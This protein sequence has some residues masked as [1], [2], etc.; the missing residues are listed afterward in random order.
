MTLRAKKKIE[1]CPK[2]VTGKHYWMKLKWYT[3]SDNLPKCSRCQLCGIIDDRQSAD[4]P[5]RGE[6]M[7]ID[8]KTNTTICPKCHRRVPVKDMRIGMIGWHSRRTGSGAAPMTDDFCKR[9]KM[10]IKKQITEVVE[11]VQSE[12]LAQRKKV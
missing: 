7:I 9:H 4:F 10:V 12:H 1:K 2:T 8:E 3:P 6:N 5:R 11:V